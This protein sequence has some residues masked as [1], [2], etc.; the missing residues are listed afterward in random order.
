MAKDKH[1]K[2]SEG[3]ASELGYHCWELSNLWQRKMREVLEPF[4]LTHVQLLLLKSLSELEE[5]KK[6]ATQIDIA[7]HA[8]CD[9]M[10]V[11][12]VLR[13]LEKKKL[14]KRKTYHLDARAKIL[15]LTD[16]AKAIITDAETQF[17]LANTYFFQSLHNKQAQ[18]E[19][20]VRKLIRLNQNEDT[21][22]D[23]DDDDE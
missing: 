11:S 22:P 17:E 6:H 16:T 5:Q 15:T 8:N 9:K 18:L 4:G 21:F 23:D 13:D 7:R 12:K 20:R 3:K 2:S 10:M 19:K 1:K 14:L